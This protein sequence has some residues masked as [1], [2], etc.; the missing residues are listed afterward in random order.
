MR[1]EDQLPFEPFARQFAA[2]RERV[3]GLT[4]RASAGGE[5][6]RLLDQAFAEL[7]TTIEELLVTEEELRVQNE[8]LLASRL[9]LEDERRRYQDL[10][11]SAPD[12]YFVTD[13]GGIIGE[14][15]EAAVSLL[16]FRR[17]PALI[18]K[19]LAVYVSEEARAAFYR[20]L[21]VL[22]Q[23]GPLLSG[24]QPP[25][26]AT[27][28]D[29]RLRPR[30]GAPVD[31]AVTVTVVRDRGGQ[32]AG[33]RW[34]VR[35]AAPRRQAEEERYRLLADTMP[36]IAWTTGPGGGIDYYNKVWYEFSGLTF[37]QTR[38]W[39]WQPVIHPDDVA[40]ATSVWRA[41]LEAGVPSEVEYRLRRADG[42]YRWHLG[43]SVPVKDGAGRVLRW[44]GTATDITERWE[45]E[46][47]REQLLIEAEARAEREAVINRVGLAARAS[48]NLRVVQAT[49]LAVLGEHLAADRCFYVLYD[50]PQD[51]CTVE[52]DW[53]RPHLP[54]LAGEYRLSEMGLAVEEVF[55]GGQTVV[56]EDVRRGPLSSETA[57]AFERIGERS[58]V[59]VPFYDRGRPTAAFV[60]A[61]ADQPRKW[62]AD[63]VET[64]EAVAAQVRAAVETARANQR[65]RAIA[66]QLQDAL[67]PT[68]SA[69]IP[70]LAVVGHYQAALTEAEIGGDFY[71][72]FPVENGCH[73]LVVGDVSGKGLAA[74]S[75]LATLRNMLR[76]FLYTLPTLAEAVTALNR[77]L[78]ENGLL[79]GFA[80]LFVGAYDSGARTLNY[81]N[82]GQEPGLLWRAATGAVEQLLPTGPILGSISGATFREERISLA[83]SDCL[84]LF[85][86][87]LTD[88]G[89]TRR[90]MLGVEGVEALLLACAPSAGETAQEVAECVA[91]RLIAG[92]E[93]HA[94]GVVGDDVCLLIGAVGD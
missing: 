62:T 8:A 67:R 31:A 22:A 14:V 89:P 23:A 69:D 63:E 42:V 57:A 47:E 83:P 36:Q 5:S 17:R 51:R 21:T 6:G 74:A 81:V 3:V 66:A 7:G 25:S 68:N 29:L 92:M 54:P 41:A 27:E 24:N 34:L 56:I 20:D 60:V 32:P 87:G 13:M 9:A 1:Q 38:D 80:T 12:A 77:T 79:T 40:R 37:E 30:S 15:N 28:R 94:Q 55:R 26:V 76:A 45:L 43:R 33:L 48:A 73:A 86:D 61:M 90:E 49:A 19:P 75:Q 58:L 16:G 35:D 59:G 70:G 11:E 78:A 52:E 46:Q 44:V 82:A 39:G 71:D 93:A 53:H 50:V 10:F 91:G 2:I 84:A 4:E 85:T 64:V 65:E 88:A 18:G 72:V